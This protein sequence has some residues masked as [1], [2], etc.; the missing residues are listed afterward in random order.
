M[1]QIIGGIAYGAAYCRK[2][3]E[4]Q[5]KNYSGYG[6]QRGICRIWK[7]RVS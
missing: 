5:D 1:I 2:K 7:H 3:G 6:K 4:R